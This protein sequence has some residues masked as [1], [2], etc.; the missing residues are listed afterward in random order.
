MN[1]TPIDQVTTEDQARNLA[2]D[3]QAIDYDWSY[4]ELADWQAYFEELAERFDLT[5]EFKE[6]GII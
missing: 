6:N 4:G 5:D 2:I 1:Q 3:W